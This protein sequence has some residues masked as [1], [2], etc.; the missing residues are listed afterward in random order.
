MMEK[1]K[2][3]YTYA[4]ISVLFL[5]F[6]PIFSKLG[7]GHFGVETTV[8]LWFTT[9][10]LFSFVLILVTGKLKEYRSFKKHWRYII[11]FG[12]LNTI[13]V[14]SSY[15]ALDIIGASLHAFLMRFYLVIMVFSGLLF[16]K[17]K[18]NKYES[19]SSVC[20]ILGVLVMSY[21][22]GEYI[23]IGILLLIVFSLMYVITRTII[24]TKLHDVPA[25]LIVNY[26][27]MTILVFSFIYAVLMG[28]F[29]VYLTHGL[30]F[31]TLPAILSAVLAHIFIFKA[32]K[33]IDLSKTE[34]IISVQPVFVTILAWIVFGETLTL[35][36]WCGGGMIL[37]GAIGLVYFRDKQNTDV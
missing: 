14:I 8:V 3:G 18:Y 13:G 31:A 2:L 27:A 32:Y 34:L 35:T 16:L 6:W 23:L 4:L 10:S 30:W 26:R 11:L 25:L 20:L 19:V 9:A 36:Q 7:F 12:F 21:S 1:K 37:L 28:K 15:Y 29:H 22:E 24:K 5:I 33:L 17:E